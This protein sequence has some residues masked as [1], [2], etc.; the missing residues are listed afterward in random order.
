MGRHCGYLAL[1]AS[2]ATGSN[3]VLIPE[4]PPEGRLG[5]PDVRCPAGQ[6]P[7]PPAERGAGRRG[8]QDHHGKR[9]TVG[10]V[11]RLLE[12]G[13]GEDARVTILGHVQRGGAPSAFDRYLGTLLGHAAVERL[14]A[15]AP[16]IPAQLVGIRGHQVVSSPLLDCIGQTRAADERIRAQDLDGAMRLRG[17]SFRDSFSILTTMQQAAPRPRPPGTGGSGW[18]WCTAAGPRRA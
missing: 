15:D 11:K 10:E 6:R 8:A 3:W 16:G 7:G 5:H 12:E 4:R 2:L 13:L 14:L 17:G 1:M 18:R 9:I